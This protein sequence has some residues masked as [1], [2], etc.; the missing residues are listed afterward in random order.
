LEIRGAG[1]ILGDA[2]SGDIQSIGFSLYTE[3][4]ERAVSSLQEGKEP[5]LL[6]PIHRQTEIDLKIPALIPEAYLHDVHTRLIFYKRISDC[7]NSEA[8]HELQV[9]MIDRF[10][11]LPDQLKNLFRIA[12]LKLR[13]Y[14]LGILKIE[15]GP[16]GG[17]F[18]LSEQPNL[19]TQQL[20]SLIQTKPAIYKLRGQTRLMITSEMETSEQ[21]LGFASSLIHD[22]TP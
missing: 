19:N 20:I 7:K 18:E 16:K 6:A 4:L 12:E 8:L 1:E 9:E 17:L 10:G 2:Q 22:L 15:L 3:L 21:R 11:F 13:A 14:P 5:D